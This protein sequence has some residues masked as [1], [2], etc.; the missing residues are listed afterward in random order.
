[1]LSRLKSG[2]LLRN[3]AQDNYNP[4]DGVANMADVMLV[5]ATGLLLSLIVSWNVDIGRNDT[6]VELERQA[7]ITEL[8]GLTESAPDALGDPAGYQELGVV[9]QDPVTGKMYMIVNE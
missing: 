7:E 2:K 3:K 4:M 5:L 1:M 6:L 9:Y 8:E